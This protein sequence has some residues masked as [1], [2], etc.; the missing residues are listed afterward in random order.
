MQQRYDGG[1]IP[2]FTGTGWNGTIQWNPK[3]YSKVKL[4]LSRQPL[5]TTLAGTNLYLVTSSTADWAYDWNSRMTSHINFN[6]YTEDF[7]GLGL[8]TKNYSYGIGV[9]YRMRRWLK[10]SLNWTNWAKTANQPAFNYFEY[11]RNV[12]MLTLTGT[13]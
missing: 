1:A 9:D 5:Q 8:Y 6:R 11:N 12:V 2:N 4:D 13:L 3:T 10:G 7:G